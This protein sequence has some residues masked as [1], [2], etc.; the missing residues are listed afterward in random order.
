MI[1][2]LHEYLLIASFLKPF[3]PFFSSK[4][5]IVFQFS[6]ENRVEHLKKQVKCKQKQ[7]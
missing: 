6:T 2:I 5:K 3:L 1:S 7:K 4:G